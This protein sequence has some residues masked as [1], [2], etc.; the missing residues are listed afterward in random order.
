MMNSLIETL[1]HW[2]GNFLGFAWPMLWQSSLLI[3]ALFAVDLL[4]RRKLRA[5]I[6]YAL[7]L[8]VLVK[9]CVPPT[10]AL[11]TSPAWW[12]HKAPPPAVA[13]PARHYTVTY[14]EGPLPELPQ[15]PLPAFVPPQ[16][17]MTNA[18]W[19]LVVSVGFSSALLLWLLGRWWQITR[20]VQRATASERLASISDEA[21]TIIGM[22]LKVRVKLTTNSMSPAVCGLFRPSILIPQSLADNFSDDQ[23][24]AVLLHELIHLRRRDVWLNFAQ[25]LVQISYWWHPLVWLAN[26]RI[27]RVREEAVDD[28]V[29]L[30]LRDKAEAYAPTLLEVAKLALNR[31]LASLGLV[32]ILESRHALRQRIERLV[33]F[34]PPRKSGLTLVSLLGI[35]AFTAVAVPMGDG[36]SPVQPAATSS[37]NAPN[38]NTDAVIVTG[39]LTDPNFRKVIHALEQQRGVEAMPEPEVVTTSGRSVNRM[40]TDNLSAMLAHPVSESSNL[41][42]MTFKLNQPIRQN[43]LR[44]KLLAAG[45]KIP[46]TVFFYHE[47]GL[48]LVRGSE[49]QLALVNRIVLRLNGYSPV[50]IEASDKHFPEQIG[51]IGFAGNSDTNLFGRH[52]RV[53][54]D[55]FNSTLRNTRG[56]QTNNFSIMAKSFFS[57]LGVDWE[58]PK[59]KAIFYNDRV[60]ELFVRATLTDF[61]TVERALVVIGPEE[62]NNQTM[63][64]NRES[65]GGTNSNVVDNSNF[66]L[67][68]NVVEKTIQASRLVQAAKE[69]YEMGKM[70][71]A[72]NLLQIALSLDAQN[73]GAKYY[74][75]LVQAARQT[76][77]GAK[78]SQARQEIFRKL[79]TIRL[80]RV[81][82]EAVPLNEVVRRLHE[83]SLKLDPDHRG[84]NFLINP[85]PD[86]NVAPTIDP[87]TGMPAAAITGN[88]S[89]L[90]SIP[91]TINPPLTNIGLGDVLD[92]LV[93][94]APEPIQYS[95]QDYAIVISPHNPSVPLYSRHFQVDANKFRA[96]MQYTPGINTNSV[97]AM[98]KDFFKSLGVDL[99]VPGKSVFFNDGMSELFV[100]ATTQDLDTIENA[101]ETFSHGSPQIHI[102]AYFLKVPKGTSDGLKNFIAVTNLPSGSNQVTGLVGILTDNNFR[103]VLRILEARP[104]VETLAEPEVVTM[105]GR[106]TQMRV[107]ETITTVITNYV[108]EENATNGRVWLN[109][110]TSQIETGP[111][112]DVVPYVLS[113]GYTINLTAIPS[114]TKFLGYDAPAPTD[115]TVTNNRAGEKIDVPKS[116]PRFTVWKVVATLNLW[117]NQTAVLG[118]LPENDYINGKKVADKSKSS[119]KELL[120]FI[121]ATM[122]DAAGNR[123][124]SDDELPFAKESIPSQPAA[125]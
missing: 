6:R 117:D 53:N 50:E 70:D 15:T 64:G 28:A 68:T 73:S 122:V 113:D 85:N 9:L 42:A 92:A 76:T 103:S 82:F 67:R 35:L 43:E 39:V 71:D 56:L 109:T 69:N 81:A 104:G 40:R 74:L 55:A 19:L 62:S 34:R 48:L 58:S 12:L 26:A 2:G 11:P 84:I 13:K 7:W 88:D 41:M 106:Q 61:D 24:R 98:A 91:I 63:P 110:Q 10:L 118:D 47:N 105:S 99:E 31:P 8:V 80:D 89:G 100:R 52:F 79:Q 4:L 20:L 96:A 86:Q 60:G 119:D 87:L 25:A 33:D 21:Q 101:L 78:T 45:V 16:P 14:D 75:G 3:A 116:L 18:A 90:I 112:L 51:A 111:I 72:E 38:T 66:S 57:T 22:K 83:E 108:F 37:V 114:L 123:I 94:A 29:M 46:P 30:A 120:V 93:K 44:D 23:L 65:F 124:H 54:P 59:G 5:S 77:R 32:G 17:T 102:K 97:P 95:V 121:T 125:K 107:A 27:R 1:N 115:Y 49:E 36:P